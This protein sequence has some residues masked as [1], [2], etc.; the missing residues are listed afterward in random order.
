MALEHVFSD[1]KSPG[2]SLSDSWWSS[3]YW[4]IPSVLG[5]VLYLLWDSVFKSLSLYDFLQYMVWNNLLGK[6]FFS[7]VQSPWDSVSDSCWSSSYRGIPSVLHSVLHLLG[8][9]IFKSSEW[10]DFLRYR[11]WI[12]LLGKLSWF[13]CLGVIPAHSLRGKASSNCWWSWRRGR[14]ICCEERLR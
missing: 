7:N 9:S 6:L 11:V 2:D 1:V 12:S 4:G 8:N 14:S 13:R 3:T 5:C 10:F